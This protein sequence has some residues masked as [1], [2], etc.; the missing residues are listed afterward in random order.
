MIEKNFKNLEEQIQIFLHKGMIIND[1]KYA[2]K[3]LLRENYFFIN[4]YRHLFL[5]SH[6]EIGRAHV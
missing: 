1:Q 3:V 2:E 5:K 6:D 4:G